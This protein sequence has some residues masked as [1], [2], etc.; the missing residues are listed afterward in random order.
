MVVGGR[1]FSSYRVGGVFLFFST[2]SSLNSFFEIVVSVFC[3]IGRRMAM[4]EPNF[5]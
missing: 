2:P 3:V 4:A 1:S 5:E